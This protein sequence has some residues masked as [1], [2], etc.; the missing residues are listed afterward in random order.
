MVDIVGHTSFD[1]FPPIVMHVSDLHI[2]V[3]IYNTKFDGSDNPHTKHSNDRTTN[4]NC[5]GLESGNAFGYEWARDGRVGEGE[6]A[7]K[8]FG[9][10]VE[11]K[12]NG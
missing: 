2:W 4:G 7:M 6:R 8:G 11:V 10:V 5:P 9:D 12:A 3:M 1:P